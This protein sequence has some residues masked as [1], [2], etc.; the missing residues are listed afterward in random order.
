MD[1]T[2]PC[3]TCGFDLSTL[4]MTIPAK[5]AARDV[6][7][8]C[9][10]CG[11][12]HENLMKGR[13]FFLREMRDKDGNITSKW[14][15]WSE[16]VQQAQ[17]TQGPRPVPIG[18]LNIQFGEEAEAIRPSEIYFPEVI[19]F[20]RE[21]GSE[22]TGLPDLPVKPEYMDC[23]DPD[24]LR[25]IR[26]PDPKNSVLRPRQFDKNGKRMY[27]CVL[28]LRELPRE[29]WHEEIAKGGG[30]VCLPLSAEIE[31]TFLRHWPNHDDLRWRY[32]VVSL[33][34]DDVKGK[35]ELN[36]PW[37]VRALVP[38]TSPNSAQKL[39][40]D[41]SILYAYR[42]PT[43][44]PKDPERRVYS[45]AIEG[46]DKHQGRPAWISVG[47]GGTGG[48]FALPP[49]REFETTAKM[50]FGLDFG[51]SN[52]VVATQ[53]PGRA[54]PDTVAPGDTT[55]WIFGHIDFRLDPDDLWLGV[56]WSGQHHDLL[57]S[58]L[59]LRDRSWHEYNNRPDEVSKLKLGVELGVPLTM[60]LP[61]RDLSRSQ[62]RELSLL[63]DFKWRRQLML[64][65][66]E[67]LAAEA[68]R[69]QARFIEAAML[70]AIA[71]QVK[72]TKQ[73]PQAV[74]VWYSYPPA[75]DKKTELPM[76][77]RACGDAQCSHAHDPLSVA[78]RLQ[79]ILSLGSPASF[80]KGPDEASAAA[81]VKQDTNRE[82]A[83]FVDI[84]G[85]SLEVVVRDQFVADG[86]DGHQG[87]DPIVMSR[88]LYFGGG[89]YLRSLI[90]VREKGCTLP[91][92][93]YAQLASRVRRYGSGSDFIRAPGIISPGRV[94][95]ARLRAEVFGEAIAD[96]VARTLAALCL[97]HG[98]QRGEEQLPEQ[99]RRLNLTRNRLF[100]WDGT[101][102]RLGGDR[103]DQRGVKFS[104]FLLGNGWSTV[105]I[106]IKEGIN[107]NVEK[108]FSGSVQARLYELLRQ[109]QA[110]AQR[111][112]DGEVSL[113]DPDYRKQLR[114]EVE[115]PQIVREGDRGV[116][117]HR[118]AVVA[119]KVLEKKQPGVA[120]VDVMHRG[121][122]G[123]EMTVG[124]RKIEW[125]RPY[126]PAQEPS[127][128]Q[129]YGKLHTARRTPS[130][131]ALSNQPQQRP[132]ASPGL[133]PPSGD[134]PPSLVEGPS[135][136]P[137]LTHPAVEW[138]LATPA[139]VAKGQWDLE[140]LIQELR[141]EPNAG[142]WLLWKRGEVTV[143][144]AVRLVPIVWNR[145]R[146]AEEW[147]VALGVT[148]IGT[149]LDLESAKRV[150]LSSHKP[151]ECKVWRPGSDFGRAWKSVVEVPEFASVLAAEPPPLDGP[152]PLDE[153]GPPPLG[154]S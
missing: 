118:K 117:K 131:V 26:S 33:G 74:D 36:R 12:R 65:G 25:E 53:V 86:K 121:A 5:T 132:I 152:P 83:V 107:S 41:E 89:V 4:P 153:D 98:Y 111:I 114:I 45:T 70:M 40:E 37:D 78:G 151:R 149:K 113:Y 103:G 57:P 71:A 28:P 47:A 62:V 96:Y 134:R 84:G 79:S 60:A 39:A 16:A 95:A 31:G 82:F 59:L 108:F 124:R 130:R 18:R 43:P 120:P 20:F 101:Q 76:L 38:H 66:F 128:A 81:W 14:V 87:L 148:Q 15:Y 27:E 21:E 93:N 2:I 91:G 73:Y 19:R 50:E 42:L 75:F 137:S 100:Y 150:V 125:Y 32:H 146:P 136:P 17:T 58:E 56:P 30:K 138:Y 72:N 154:S 99:K 46:N 112:T 3:T 142:D 6:T 8:Y 23:L 147:S 48:V 64:N 63:N 123:L 69:T 94:Q 11:K 34:F 51:T 106:A 85:G 90:S 109:E 77:E 9:P 119:T 139:R 122:L 110:I 22:R 144:T 67:G 104:I 143:W 88:S 7:V 24:A 141:R 140:A 127:D 1:S 55:R 29:K 54:E 80:N 129:D 35:S 135:G 97:E 44:T 49:G 68:W 115:C 105:E 13:G 10:V 92:I 52:T 61:Q 145:V 126:G 102:W 133:Q 116:V